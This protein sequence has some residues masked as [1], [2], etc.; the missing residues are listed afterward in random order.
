LKTPL[1][2]EEGAL[3]LELYFRQILETETWILDLRSSRFSVP[4]DASRPNLTWTPGPYAIRLPKVFV[5]S[6]RDLYIGFYL[7]QPD[8]FDQALKSLGVFSAKSILQ[9]HFGVED[10]KAIRFNLA[11]FERVFA[12]VFSSCAKAGDKIAPEFAALGMIL[13]TL[14]ENLGSTPFTYDVRETFMK[15]YRASQLQTDEARK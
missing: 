10:Q 4:V 13:L 9:A 7:G 1:L 14:Y 15:A 2:W 5:Q 8:R 12:D 3:I 11:E 6:V